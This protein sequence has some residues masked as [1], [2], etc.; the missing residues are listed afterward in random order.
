MF[1]AV[2]AQTAAGTLPPAIEVKAMEDCTV[3]GRTV[4]KRMPLASA[5]V[6]NGA[7][8]RLTTKPSSGNSTKV[9]ARMVRC[10]RQWVAP[11]ITV[12]RDSLAPCRKKSSAMARSVAIEKIA[13]AR[14]STGRSEARSTV[15]R[16]PG[17]GVGAEFCEHGERLV[18]AGS[19]RP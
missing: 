15:P 11:A 9:Q 17:E 6:S 12:S 14:P 2:A 4:R 5:G 10:S 1:E 18:L 19:Q 3:E 13:A 16:A 7:K 8:V